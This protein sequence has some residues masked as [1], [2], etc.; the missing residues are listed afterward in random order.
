MD[1]SLNLWHAAEKLEDIP[2]DELLKVLKNNNLKNAKLIGLF[3]AKRSENL[4]VLN[5]LEVKNR[6]LNVKLRCAF[7]LVRREHAAKRTKLFYLKETPISKL[8][9]PLDD[10]IFGL[11]DHMEFVRGM[12]FSYRNITGK[13]LNEE[14]F[15]KLF[16]CFDSFKKLEAS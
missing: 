11:K 10:P 8:D 14:E 9:L 6:T 15:L 13:E 7:E 2:S 4:D 3:A 16:D 5:V 1:V 12:M